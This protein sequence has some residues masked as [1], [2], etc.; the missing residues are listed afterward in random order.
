MRVLPAMA[1][2]AVALAT[3]AQADLVHRYS[4]N[5]T[6]GTVVKDSV[7]SADGVLKGS[8]GA[9]DGSGKLVLPGGVTSNVAADALAGYVDLPNGIISVLTNATFEAWVT[10]DGGTASLWQRIFD[11][12]TSATGEN[13]ANGNGDYLFLCPVTSAQ[14]IRFAVRDPATQ[15]ETVI[16]NSATVLAG[17]VEAC[18]T[19]S[20]DHTANASRV[21]SNGVLIA[22]APAS[23]ALSTIHDVNNWLG[24]S[25]WDD[26]MFQGSYD[27]FRIYNTAL[28]SIEV[29]GSYANGTANP[30]TDPG[31][32]QAVHLGVKNATM[33]QLDKQTATLT[34]DFA[35]AK[36]VSLLDIAS[37]TFQSDKPDVVSVGAA[38][39]ISAVGAGTAKLT[40]TYQGQTDTTSITVLRRSTGPID[41]G[42]LYVD[43]LAADT[44]AGGS[45]WVNKT[46][47]GDFTGANN[48]VYVAD[49]EGTGVAGVQ[50]NGTTDGFAGPNTTTDL[51]GASDRSIEVWVY[52]PAIRDEETLV[53]LGHRGGPDG[54]N[55]SFNYGA[56]AT[57]GAVGHWGA[58][59]MGWGTVPAAG[60][61]HYLVYTY[62]GDLNC[63]VYADGVLKNDRTQ[64]AA[65]ATYAD[66][67]IRL[68][69]QANTAGDDF[70]FAQAFSGYIARVRV[71]GGKLI[72]A[73]VT[74]NFFYGI[75]LTAPGA[76]Q[77]VALKMSK[78]ELVGIGA[79]VN[80][81]VMATFASRNYLNVSG[82]ATFA[83]SDPSV[84]TVDKAGLITAVQVGTADITATF[85][86][87]QAK[88]TV[89]VKD[90]P[91]AKLI[92]RYSFSEAPG[93]TTVKD[94]AGTA[95]GTVKGQGADFTG[96][97]QLMLPGGGTSGADPVPGYVD[98]PNHII[99]VL[100][101]L[102]IAAWITYEAPAA[103]A[104][105]R[106]FDFGT[107]DGGE[108]VVNGN[109]NYIFMTPEGSANFRFALRDPATAS[110]PI[111]LTAGAPLATGQ[112]MCVAVTYNYEGNSTVLYSNAVALVKGTASVA[113][114]T[115]ND[116]N[117]WLGR[118][119]WN[120]AMF[121]GKYDEF[122]IYDGAMSA[123][124]MAAIVAAG[125]DK[126]PSA[127]TTKPT[128]TF[129]L[130]AGKLVIG[131]PATASTFTLE[132]TVAL[133]STASWTKVD[134]SGAV[135]QGGNKQ[136][137]LTLDGVSK[138]YRMK[139]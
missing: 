96:Q 122:R 94:S 115:I 68:G 48:P 66:L 2:S 56:N 58:F 59:D 78:T 76:L 95:D 53:A 15:S 120:D 17:G 125:P 123:S 69:A 127:V 12:G 106:I 83:S 126:L 118:S 35:K 40:L 71:H 34:A 14:T 114:S 20:Y 7:G 87:K 97:G 116:V 132:S 29:A 93:T 65:L 62:D 129:G 52:N 63:R 86:G 102:T 1:I 109:G 119:Q 84:A 113:L 85:D 128:I 28:N 27:E 80:A 60:Q 50:F 74:N 46:G 105:G 19:V 44:K 64:T 75:E 38:G 10:Y 135:D 49:V 133:G 111:V 26:A 138:F 57:Y 72:E 25:Q 92:H 91:S 117:N 55:L 24:R 77:A 104:W 103:T 100:T 88:Q 124:E 81:S 82:F 131:W 139:Q 107:S 70:D 36:G 99:N 21:Y 31:A 51:D 43:L 79:N 42:T 30:T 5:E 4:F 61:W 45:S 130:A 9:F 112:E 8:G 110:E 11:F 22:S 16:A 73:D 37:A 6:S 67:P 54:S 89:T 136:L 90:L 33:V 137:S 39:A 134:I 23:V 32:L 41:A 101:N 121:Q 18:L 98:L 13:V 108:D 3:S 47:K